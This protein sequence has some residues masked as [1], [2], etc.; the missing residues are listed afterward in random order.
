MNEIILFNLP[1]FFKIIDLKHEKNE[2]F[3]SRNEQIRIL[4]NP[5]LRGKKNWTRT[6]FSLFPK[7]FRPLFR[8]N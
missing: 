4:F 5:L 7:Q 1:F 6:V 3:L 8:K 2:S